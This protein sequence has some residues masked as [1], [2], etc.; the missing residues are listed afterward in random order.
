MIVTY[1]SSWKR[2]VQSSTMIDIAKIAF[3]TI[4]ACCAWSRWLTCWASQAGYRLFVKKVNRSGQAL[5]P[6]LTMIIDMTLETV[7][8]TSN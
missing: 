4:D 3:S 7:L 6:P 2:L 1:A 5:K 8:R